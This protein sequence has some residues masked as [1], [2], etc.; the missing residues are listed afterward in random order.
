MVLHVYEFRKNDVTSYWLNESCYEPNPRMYA[1]MGLFSEP[2]PMVAI[3]TKAY[4]LLEGNLPEHNCILFFVIGA[5][6]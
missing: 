1:D 5:V 3:K 2:A 4:L 6:V